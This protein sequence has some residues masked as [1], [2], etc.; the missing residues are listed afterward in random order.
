VNEADIS[1]SFPP[2]LCL[3]ARVWTTQ[4]YRQHGPLEGPLVDI[5]P[6]MGGTVQSIDKPHYA[7]SLLY[8]VRW[9]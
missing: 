9:G 4:G 2:H 7:D 1:S 8:S 6:N 5:L 3:G